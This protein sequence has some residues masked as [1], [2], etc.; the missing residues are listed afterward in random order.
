[1]I[2]NLEQEEKELKAILEQMNLEGPCPSSIFSEESKRLLDS[3]PSIGNSQQLLK[4]IK[5]TIYEQEFQADSI[6][7]VT[8]TIGNMQSNA[9]EFCSKAKK[10]VKYHLETKNTGQNINPMDIVANLS[11]KL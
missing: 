1:M 7:M 4:Q 6:I 11:Q 2:S 10:A 5:D 9:D 8:G 3:T